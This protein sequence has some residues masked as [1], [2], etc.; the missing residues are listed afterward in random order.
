MLEVRVLRRERYAFRCGRFRLSW[1]ALRLAFFILMALL[2]L[3]LSIWRSARQERTVYDGL[4][5]VALVFVGLLV[6]SF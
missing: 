3:S 6:P 5:N 2:L 4:W 1:R